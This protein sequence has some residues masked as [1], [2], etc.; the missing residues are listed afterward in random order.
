MLPVPL[1]TCVWLSRAAAGATAEP[2]PAAVAILPLPACSSHLQR[3]SP[4]CCPCPGGSSLLGHTG[5]R[6]LQR[7]GEVPGHAGHLHTPTGLSQ[8]CP[9]AGSSLGHTRLGL[10]GAF[11]KEPFIQLLFCCFECQ[12]CSAK[13]GPG[14]GWGMQDGG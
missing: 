11:P 1:G 2:S 14:G 6:C 8:L 10:E 5:H 13:P 9:G 4:G 3:T 12:Q 7:A